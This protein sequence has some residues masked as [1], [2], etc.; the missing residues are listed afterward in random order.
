M[1]LAIRFSTIA[2]EEYDDAFEWY[3][4]QSLNAADRFESSISRSLTRIVA[5]PN[6]LPSTFAGCRR[7]PVEQ[8]P[9]DI[10]YHQLSDAIV[11]IAIAHRKRRPGYW[12]K[13]MSG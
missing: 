12:R 11:V 10:I 13:R 4:K 3:A 7:C 9:F 2:R 8:Y 5:A 6:R 1:S